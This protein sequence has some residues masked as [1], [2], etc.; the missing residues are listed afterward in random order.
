MPPSLAKWGVLG[1]CQ[2][3]VATTSAPLARP[4]SISRLMRDDAVAA[5]DGQAAGGIGEVVL[6]VDDDE[7]RSRA[8]ALHGRSVPQR[9]VRAIARGRHAR[10]YYPMSA[11]RSSGDRLGSGRLGG[12]GG[13]T[14]SR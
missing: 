5:G 12:T 2:S 7:C 4:I 14:S 13:S 11:D 8:V 1:G 10:P 9:V 6:D 3:W